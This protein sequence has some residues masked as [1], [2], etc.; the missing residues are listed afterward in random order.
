MAEWGTAPEFSHIR[1][2]WRKFM[3]N[4]NE[5]GQ[6]D[7]VSDHVLELLAFG[8]DALQAGIAESDLG[9]L[10]LSESI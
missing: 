7:I 2:E 1:P 10:V 3:F 8:G 9:K 4:V 6:S 5:R